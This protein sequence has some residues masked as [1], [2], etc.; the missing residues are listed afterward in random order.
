MEFVDRKKEI[1]R[2][3]K[4]LESEKKRFIVIYGRRP[5]DGGGVCR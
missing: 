4:A 2:L 3:R 5:P 1:L